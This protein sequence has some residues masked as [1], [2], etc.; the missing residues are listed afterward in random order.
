MG[1]MFKHCRFEE[2]DV[3]DLQL[4]DCGFHQCSFT[5]SHGE[6]ELASSGVAGGE[7]VGINCVE[8]CDFAGCTLLD[9]DLR[10]ASTRGSIW[11]ESGASIRKSVR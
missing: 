5:G 4:M 9:V 8:E 3:K 11:P 1:A 10:S 2:S 7:P 6:V